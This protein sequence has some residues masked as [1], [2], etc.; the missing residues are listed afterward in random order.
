MS[1]I[2]V[3]PQRDGEPDAAAAASMGLGMLVILLIGVIL[4]LILAWF[5]IRP[6]LFT[7][8]DVV[9]PIALSAFLTIAG[10]M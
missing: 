6:I 2:R 4:L 5:L 8:T 3:R 9:T 1:D 7:P 10:A